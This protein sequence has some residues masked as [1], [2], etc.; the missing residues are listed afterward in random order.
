[1]S[2]IRSQKKTLNKALF[3]NFFSSALSTCLSLAINYSI[4]VKHCNLGVKKKYHNVLDDP[5]AG[6][7]KVFFHGEPA[8]QKNYRR[9]FL[10][11]MSGK[12]Y[13]DNNLLR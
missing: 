12:I 6:F 13:Y 8:S 3:L 1:M 5:P 2:K 10:N 4:I 11:V 9:Q 7:T